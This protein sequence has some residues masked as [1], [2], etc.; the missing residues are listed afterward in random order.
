[1]RLQ[2]PFRRRL[3]V[4]LLLSVGFIVTIAGVVRTYYC[5]KGLM[6]SWDQTWFTFPLWISAAV[7]VDLAVVSCIKIPSLLL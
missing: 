7:E 1:M 5:W 3:G 6:D 2:M 4:M